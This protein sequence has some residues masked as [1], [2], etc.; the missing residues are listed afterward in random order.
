[1]AKLTLTNI[2]TGYLS[3]STF[4][5]NNDAIEAALENT[6][7]RDGTSPNTM[8]ADI[9][10]NSNRATNLV[11]G[12]N[13]QDAVTVAQLA[14]AS[15]VS[16]TTTAALVTV[17]DSAGNYD[18]TTVEGVLA[19]LGGTTQTAEAIGT[20]L[21]PASSAE[22][23]ASVTPT[24]YR[25]P[26][27]FIERYGGVADGTT[28]STTALETA[29]SVGRQNIKF[30]ETGRTDV[31]STYTGRHRHY[32]IRDAFID[33]GN[34]IGPANFT[35]DGTQ[36]ESMLRLGREP[37]NSN[38]AQW[39][40]RTVE[41]I[42]FSGKVRTDNGISFGA[43][44][45]WRTVEGINFSGKVR[46]D[47]GI[48][49]GADDNYPNNFATSW[50]IDRCRFERCNI[51]IKKATGNFG[52]V[53]RDTSSGSGNY[54]Y[55]VR[56]YPVRSSIGVA[57]ASGQTVN[58]MN[59]LDVVR[60]LMDD[61]SVHQTTIV[62]VD[63]STQITITDPT[64]DTAAVGNYVKAYHPDYSIPVTISPPGSDYIIGGEWS[65]HY[66]AAFY[67]D[68][69]NVQGTGQHV[70][71]GCLVEQNAGYGFFVKDYNNAYTP[72]QLSNVWFEENGKDANSYVT[73]ADGIATSQTP[74]AAGNFTLDG[75]L[76]A[77]GAY[78]PT[79]GARQISFTSASN[80]SG[81]T[82]TIT[83]TD[84]Y[85]DA[86]TEAITGPNATTVYSTKSWLT[87]TQ[88]ATD[89]AATG[90]ITIGV[91][92]KVDHAD[93]FGPREPKDIYFENVDHAI[94]TGSHIR[95]CEFIDSN[96]SIDNCAL[97][98]GNTEFTI[99]NTNNLNNI[100]ITNA[101]IFG[102][103]ESNTG[104]GDVE[105]E[106]VLRCDIEAGDST[107]RSWRCPTRIP[108]NINDVRKGTILETDTGEKGEDWIRTPAADVSRD[109]FVEGLTYPTASQYTFTSSD[110]A[111]APATMSASGIDNIGTF[112]WG[113]SYS[114]TAGAIQD[115]L[116]TGEWA[117]VAFVG[118]LAA[119]NSGDIRP[120]LTTT[121]GG[122]AQVT[123]GATQFVEFDTAQEA[124]TFYNL[125]VH[126]H[127]T[128]SVKRSRRSDSAAKNN[129]TYAD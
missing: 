129:S 66:K 97:E 3:T 120:I 35:S 17:A 111:S 51:A 15:V 40:W 70:W 108:T 31:L 65:G 107:A 79:T 42:N 57:E 44:W 96:V 60:I 56:G 77:G 25:Y 10:F 58:G 7:S 61:A 32:I 54:G 14:A 110:T 81:D 5:D 106:S 33:R 2:T 36:T 94:I 71:Q 53:I 45:R 47:N 82:Y 21:Q 95:I 12:A 126:V 64:D 91:T 80:E 102:W 109:G 62:S 67:I 52:Q 127:Q 55:W 78:T 29:N 48:S 59:A 124:Y 22:T 113:S 1:M 34:L 86:D 38:G 39:R 115:L 89:G 125:G 20:V 69:E 28:D 4:N 9:D 90:A 87:I 75:A 83:G 49:F 30:Y 99:T 116:T 128:K 88:I 68:G 84:V 41:G 93:G 103:G 18:A 114:F 85:G 72:L 105:V 46:T 13:N 76:T 119:G 121:A 101:H 23:D 16:N 92:G 100:H 117:T 24:A 11:D 104:A 26:V 123:F 118:K 6:L 63:S 74:G 19:E 50:L 43:Q 73:D 98:N 8:S 122:S 37:D 112:R 27:G